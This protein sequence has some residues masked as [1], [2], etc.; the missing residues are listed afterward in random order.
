M[1]TRRA[2]HNLASCVGGHAVAPLKHA[3]RGE[4]FERLRGARAGLGAQRL[5]VAHSPGEAL[6]HGLHLGA[7][8]RRLRLGLVQTV[9]ASRVRL[10]CFLK[11]P[12]RCMAQAIVQMLQLKPLRFEARGR[13]LQALLQPVELLGAGLQA[14]RPRAVP[15]PLPAGLDP[16]R[17]MPEQIRHI[18]GGLE[19]AYLQAV[20]ARN[21]GHLGKTADAAG[22]TRRTL[23]TK[24]KEYGLP[25]RPEA[26]D[27]VG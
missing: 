6:A 27:E 8:L 1:Q 15:E 4:K 17:P 2:T 22:V 7:V 25:A 26:E 9:D 12:T 5:Q 23:Y 19:R 24:L 10:K 11:L 14:A 16:D 3:L 13:W 18:L 21:D 20:L